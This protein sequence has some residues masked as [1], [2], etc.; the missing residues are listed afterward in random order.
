MVRAIRLF[1]LAAALFVIAWRCLS[2]IS[3]TVACAPLPLEAGTERVCAAPEPSVGQD[4]WASVET[5][6]DSEGEVSDPFLAPSPLEFGLPL[7][8]DVSGVGC[9]AM[10]DQGPLPGHASSLERP[11]RA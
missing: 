1:A 4:A 11:P 6:D 2:G 3:L 8:A 5:D 9:G 7:C 10:A